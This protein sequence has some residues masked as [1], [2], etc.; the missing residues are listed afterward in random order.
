KKRTFFLV[1]FQLQKYNYF[2]NLQSFL[3]RFFLFYILSYQ[4][5]SLART[6]NL[7]FGTNPLIPPE[8]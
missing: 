8:K 1:I 7:L 2:L 6:K 5:D 4:L 3:Q